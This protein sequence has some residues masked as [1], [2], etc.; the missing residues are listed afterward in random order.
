MK[1]ILHILFI[2]V[3]FA[4][5]GCEGKEP[6]IST[7][8]EAASLELFFS[9]PEI[10]ISTKGIEDPWSDP[11]ADDS[12]WTMWD[13]FTDGRALY[14]VAVMIIEEST[15][16]LVGFRHMTADSDYTDSN[17]GFWD[18]GADE[19]LDKSAVVGKAAKMSFLY[20]SPQN[21]R[22]VEKLRRGR[23]QVLA[24]G[25]FS[26]VSAEVTGTAAYN[27]LEGAIGS[28]LTI[29]TPFSDLMQGIAEE[30]EGD[31]NVTGDEGITAFKNSDEFKKI[32]DFNIVTDANHLCHKQPQPLTAVKYIELAPGMNKISLNLERTYVRVRVEIE[33]NSATEK[34]IVND[35][36]FCDWF[37]QRAVYLFN[38]PTDNSRNYD[39][40]DSGLNTYKKSPI[41]EKECVPDTPLSPG[42]KDDS[43]TYQGSAIVS[44]KESLAIDPGASMV[45]FDGYVFGSKLGTDSEDGDTYQYH[46]DVEYK[47]KYYSKLAALDIANPIT[48]IKD[49]RA[50]G[51]YVIK[52]ERD[53]G[54]LFI[55]DNTLYSSSFTEPNGLNIS[56]GDLT[57]IW[58]LEPQGDP[59]CYFV[60]NLKDGQQ[61]I[62][63]PNG[64]NLVETVTIKGSNNYFTFVNMTGGIQ[65]LSSNGGQYLNHYN[66]TENNP[67]GLYGFCGYAS[68]GDAGNKL[69][70]FQISGGGSFPAHF[71]DYVDLE[72][73]DPETAAVYPVTNIKRNDFINILVS[74]A[75]N[76]SSSSFEITSVTDWNKKSEEI[77]FH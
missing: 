44:F 73:I 2:A 68:S 16:N 39:I 43:Y 30:Y 40:S 47:D 63:T 32:W 20:D 51:N 13:I 58:T 65:L 15:G 21:S 55:K 41:L 36:D 61:Y 69:V 8:D 25:N 45:I 66:H 37:T 42:D 76:D 35:F 22:T 18:E 64:N 28:S 74:V 75:Y 38:D 10:S 71:N 49:L 54:Y 23:Y 31:K 67:Y 59:N 53:P 5:A 70:F 9:V 26:E 12:D 19:V 6:A 60:K 29:D 77:E 7:S 14:E 52:V 17:N 27:G 50:N 3:L 24:V 33:N 72:L 46:L 34:L 11:W 57:Y 48:D 56:D 62:A 4:I 1:N